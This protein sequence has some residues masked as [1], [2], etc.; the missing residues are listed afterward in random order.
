LR[1]SG[2]TCDDCDV[3]SIWF[4]SGE[5]FSQ[6]FRDL[7][8]FGE[9]KYT[10]DIAVQAVNAKDFGLGVFVLQSPLDARDQGLAFTVCGWDG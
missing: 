6:L 10:G 2:H 9:H 7:E 1:L 8:G 4:S 5:L 3:L